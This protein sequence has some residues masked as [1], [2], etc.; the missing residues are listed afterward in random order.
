MIELLK[1]SDASPW[2][3]M[4]KI[5][6][7]IEYLNKEMLNKNLKKENKMTQEQMVEFQTY[8][9]MYDKGLLSKKTVLGKIGIDSE[10]EQKEIEKD[11]EFDKKGNCCDKKGV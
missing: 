8:L 7:I 2:N 10:E 6:E 3:N 5:N 1:L 4:R 11:R 9:Q